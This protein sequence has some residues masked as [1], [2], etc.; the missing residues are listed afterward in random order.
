MN[1]HVIQKHAKLS[2]GGS[3]ETYLNSLTHSS[4]RDVWGLTRA[5]IDATMNLVKHIPEDVV[6]DLKMAATKHGMGPKA[7]H[8]HTSLARPELRVNYQPNMESEEYSENMINTKHTVRNIVA[9]VHR[10]HENV[11]LAWKPVEK[12]QES[13]KICS[14]F[15]WAL[16]LLKTD[17]PHETYESEEKML[18]N[19]FELG[20]MDER[21]LQIT[22]EQKEPFSPQMIP[23]FKTIYDRLKRDIEANQLKKRANLR[24]QI[25]TATLESLQLD[26]TSDINNATNYEKQ[27][28]KAKESWSARVTTHKRTRHSKGI[29]ATRDHMKNVMIISRHAQISQMDPDIGIM[30]AAIQ[31]TITN[32]IEPNLVLD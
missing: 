3:G 7:P 5:E 31:T 6:E 32:G 24:L 4:L 11:V 20:V 18:I 12:I 2:D 28:L 27:L 25:D 19:L 21:I 30:K 8:N 17:I 15:E 1:L 16:R 23:E 29:T 10:E 26:V 22:A 13:Q 9:R 14:L